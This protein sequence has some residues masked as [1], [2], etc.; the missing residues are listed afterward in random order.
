MGR[1]TG[2]KRLS[3]LEAKSPQALAP[4]SWKRQQSWFNASH[5][6]TVGGR[7][8]L[9]DPKRLRRQSRICLHRFH[10]EKNG[11]Q[12]PRTNIDIVSNSI[13]TMQHR[14]GYQFGRVFGY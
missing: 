5:R 6:K 2:A 8:I 7:E 9:T 14:A 12:N 3:Q 1:E 10:L 11:A 13:L 4:L